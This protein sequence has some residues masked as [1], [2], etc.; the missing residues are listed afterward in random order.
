MYGRL[1]F[2]IIAN[3]LGQ[4]KFLM[5]G[6]IESLQVVTWPQRLLSP[7]PRPKKSIK[8][9]AYDSWWEIFVRFS[10]LF[11]IIEH[12]LENGQVN[13]QLNNYTT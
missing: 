13:T 1:R 7:A 5:K 8:V 3:T 9:D 12:L 11:L 10:G 6:K 4:S 2:R